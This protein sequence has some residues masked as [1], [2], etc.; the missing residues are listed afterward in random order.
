[1]KAGAAGEGKGEGDSGEYGISWGF[2]EDAVAEEEDEDEAGMGDVDGEVRAFI[3]APNHRLF[4]CAWFLEKFHY[5]ASDLLGS[6]SLSL[7]LR[8]PSCLKM[9]RVRFI[10]SPVHG[11]ILRSRGEF[12]AFFG[13]N[14]VYSSQTTPPAPCVHAKCA[15]YTT[16]ST[17]TISIAQHGHETRLVHHATSS[18]CARKT[19]C[20][21]SITSSLIPISIDR[22][23]TFHIFTST[24]CVLCPL[25]VRR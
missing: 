22:K 3:F 4:L 16:C 5:V 11:H 24:A 25:V 12:F 2:D 18:V 17:D 10:F 8:P 9:A 15:C 23:T 13:S 14:A 19:M 20:L 7:S 21:Y 1:M 6:V